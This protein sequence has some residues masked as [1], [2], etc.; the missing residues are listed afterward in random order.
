[1]PA[2]ILISWVF[3]SFLQL[4]DFRVCDKDGNVRSLINNMLDKIF[5]RLELGTSNLSGECA[6][7][8]KNVPEHLRKVK[9]KLDEKKLKFIKGNETRPHQMFLKKK[10]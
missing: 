2:G 6:A 7:S 9:S 5:T 1:M 4:Q 10:I 8:Q 3:P